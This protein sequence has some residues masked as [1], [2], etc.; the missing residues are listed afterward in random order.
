VPLE[1]GFGKLFFAS[2]LLFATASPR[3]SAPP[4]Q[5]ASTRV[6]LDVVVAPESGPPVADLQ[7]QDFTLLDNKAPQTITSF[8]AVS[9]RQAAV[10]VI[11]V[12]D[13]VNASYQ[14]VS[15]ERAEIDKY[16]RAENG[17]LAFPVAVVALKDKGIDILGNFSTDGKALSAA[18]DQA[19]STLRPVGS[20]SNYDAGGRWHI[21]LDGLRHLIA[22][23]AGHRGRTAILWI[24]PG[25]PIFNN[26]RT[27]LS[28]K[29]QQEIFSS[30][31]NFSNDMLQNRVTLYNIDP[32]G[33]V[34]SPLRSSYF[35][36][37]LKVVPDADHVKAANL[38]L[39]VLAIH[40]GGL[41]LTSTNDV[42]LVLRQCV[43]DAAPFYEISYDPTPAAH[44]DEYH[45]VEIQIAK[46]D[47]VARTHQIYYAQPPAHN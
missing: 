21:S 38:A 43:V 46:P 8:K 11:I 44:L 22:G 14:T 1:S 26:A 4:A 5:P 29:E 13:V 9:G 27:T 32:L 37:F 41:A 35:E 36:S 12:I 39:P 17:Q 42:S 20:A 18:L 3:Q 25:W 31:V 19:G 34:E 23:V 30:V 40:S 45:R 7:A 16:L 15:Q 6:Y 2:L 47:M 24:S 33:A 28:Q 10:G